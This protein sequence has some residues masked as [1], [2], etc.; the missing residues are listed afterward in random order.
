MRILRH[1]SPGRETALALGSFDGVHSGHQAMLARVS[2]AA[3]ARGLGAGVLTF[4]PLPREHFAP[5]QAPARL[6]SFTEKVAAMAQRGLDTLIVER[7][8]AR[9]AALSPA[10]FARR[11]RERHRARWVLVGPD[12]RYG[13]QRKGD[14]ATLAA[15]IVAGVVAYFGSLALMGVR[16]ADFSR[17]E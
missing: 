12:F 5:A 1:A 13:A 4:E 14:V 8:D 15:V 9:F 17:H 3:A 6:S 2:E 16:L 10:E 11:L 7:F